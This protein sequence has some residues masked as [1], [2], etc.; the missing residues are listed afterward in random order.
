[1]PNIGLGIHLKSFD[2]DY[3]LTDIGNQS[4][5]LY[6]NMFSLTYNGLLPKRQSKQSAQ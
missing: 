5:V 6:T 1:Q 3:A 4:D 2:I